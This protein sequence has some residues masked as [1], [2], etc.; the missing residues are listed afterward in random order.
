MASYQSLKVKSV[1]WSPQSHWLAIDQK[2]DFPSFA[3]VHPIPLESIGMGFLEHILTLLIGKFDLCPW[4]PTALE[5]LSFFEYM[6][7]AG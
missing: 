5:V 6:L 1:W 4:R 2:M 7:G 3:C